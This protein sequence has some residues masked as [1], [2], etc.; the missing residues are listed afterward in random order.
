MVQIPPHKF[1]VFRF[2]GE[3]ELRVTLKKVPPEIINLD[4]RARHIHVDTLKSTRKWALDLEL[5]EDDEVM[6]TE[7]NVNATMLND[8]LL[9][10]LKLLSGPTSG[11]CSRMQSIPKETMSRTDTIV[12]DADRA[13]GMV[14]LVRVATNNRKGDVRKRKRGRDFVDADKLRSTADQIL[15]AEQKRHDL[16]MKKEETKRVKYAAVEE[17][18]VQRRQKRKQRRTEILAIAGALDKKSPSHVSNAQ[19]K[20]T[21]RFTTE[22][23]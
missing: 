16:A 3:A 17:R 12:P 9:V 20:T 7:P 23:G 15:N 13:A 4:V 6:D 22:S 10:K 14:K 21:V 8:T 11:S 2:K 18:R 19:R 1:R 5:E